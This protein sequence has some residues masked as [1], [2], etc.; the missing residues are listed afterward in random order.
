MRT[1]AAAALARKAGAH[2]HGRVG[3]EVGE[4]S[5]EPL[6]R[7]VASGW[8]DVGEA[9]SVPLAGSRIVATADGDIAVF[10]TAEAEVFA[11]RDRCPHKGG[12]LS[13]GIVAGRSVTCP[14]HNW[15][16]DL[17]SG[18]ALGG[19]RGCAA[20]IPAVVRGGRVLLGIA[21]RMKAAS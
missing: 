1:T 19:D 10:R 14:L 2:E 21:P 20:T 4:G 11:L 7:L 18:R 16:F 8:V 5:E 13:P 17:A 6:P 9:A 3:A 15:V 12:P